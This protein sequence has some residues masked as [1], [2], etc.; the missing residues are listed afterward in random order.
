MSTRSTTGRG[1]RRFVT[2]TNN[3][4]EPGSEVAEGETVRA[5]TRTVLVVQGAASS[6]TKRVEEA[7]AASA[8]S[9]CRAP[10]TVTSSRAFAPGAGEGRSQDTSAA[11]SRVPTGTGLE[12][13]A[14]ERWRRLR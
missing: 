5:I 3:V 11:K 9:P 4:A 6:S 14:K 7:S 1:L 8:R 10:F 12:C 13:A 2:T